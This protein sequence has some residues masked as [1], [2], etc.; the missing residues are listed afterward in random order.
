M[1][2]HTFSEVIKNSFVLKYGLEKVCDTITT[3]INGE[4]QHMRDAHASKRIVGKTN[5]GGLS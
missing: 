3:L 2:K 4:L 1:S 5:A